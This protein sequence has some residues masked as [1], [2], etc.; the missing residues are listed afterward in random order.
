MTRTLTI[1][2]MS[3]DHCVRR[4]RKALSSVDGVTVKDVQVGRAVIDTSDDNAAVSRA[5]EAIAGAGYSAE[6]SP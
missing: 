2:G 6:V 3:C 4:V 5:L 1:S